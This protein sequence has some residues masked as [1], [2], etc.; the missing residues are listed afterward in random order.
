MKCPFLFAL[1]A[2]L[3]DACW[4]GPRPSPPEKYA[5]AGWAP[6]LTLAFYDDADCTKPVKEH[7]ISPKGD[8]LDKV[9]AGEP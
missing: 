2:Y 9:A 5:V 1:M 4:S 6:R 7:D 8:M 3:A